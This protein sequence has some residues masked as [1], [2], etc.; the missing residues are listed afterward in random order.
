[1][2][3]RPDKKLRG[4]KSTEAIINGLRGAL[5]KLRQR[6]G[7]TVGIASRKRHDEKEEK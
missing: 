5:E 4:E 1:V 7:I 2:K 3:K 6:R